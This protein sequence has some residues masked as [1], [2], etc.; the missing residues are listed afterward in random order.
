ME[1]GFI[2]VQKVSLWPMASPF[3]FAFWYFSLNCLWHKV[4]FTWPTYPQTGSTASLL[5]LFLCRRGFVWNEKV[6]VW[7]FVT[8]LCCIFWLLQW[9]CW[10]YSQYLLSCQAYT[11]TDFENIEDWSIWT[12][13]MILWESSQRTTVCSWCS[14]R[15]VWLVQ[16][17]SPRSAR[18]I[19]SLVYM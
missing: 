4:I 11:Q 18:F 5:S 8:L 15:R 7:P 1:C 16:W 19:P 6:G 9:R 13:I 14:A 2:W 12:V 10:W 3:C 17:E